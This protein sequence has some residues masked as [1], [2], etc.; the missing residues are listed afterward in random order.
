MM[1]EERSWGNWCRGNR[2]TGDKGGSG[3][4]NEGSVL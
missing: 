2:Q 3:S 1:L 4:W